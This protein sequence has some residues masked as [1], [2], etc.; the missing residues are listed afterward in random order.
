MFIHRLT[1][2]YLKA[3]HS[4][5]LEGFQVKNQNI[6]SSGIHLWVSVYNISIS[7]N[8]SVN[9]HACK[10]LRWDLPSL[11]YAWAR[12]GFPRARCWSYRWP[13]GL[14]GCSPRITPPEETPRPINRG[15]QTSLQEPSFHIILTNFATLV[16]FISWHNV[17]ITGK[18]W[19]H[20]LFAT[21]ELPSHE[22]PAFSVSLPDKLAITKRWWAQF[23]PKLGWY[24]LYA[25]VRNLNHLDKDFLT[26]AK[27][28]VYAL[29]LDRSG[30]HF[31]D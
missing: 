18:L 27:S 25:L 21:N 12:T 15:R 5:C 2:E 17:N 3:W 8:Q 6:P 4:S 20:L 1:V 13:A 31:N 22:P 9:F 10:R 23:T 29:G 19:Y 7:E 30:E 26:D 16:S 11:W 24:Q 14:T 28:F